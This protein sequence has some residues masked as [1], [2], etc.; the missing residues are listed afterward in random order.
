MS[1]N[2]KLFAILPKV[3]SDHIYVVDISVGKVRCAANVIFEGLIRNIKLVTKHFS[4]LFILNV[5]G[6]FGQK[7]ENDTT[8]NVKYIYKT[9]V[10]STLEPQTMRLT[11]DTKQSDNLIFLNCSDSSLV[12]KVIITTPIHCQ[13]MYTENVNRIKADSLSTLFFKCL[14][15]YY[16]QDSNHAKSDTLYILDEQSVFENPKLSDEERYFVSKAEVYSADTS[17]YTILEFY[18]I[19]ELKGECISGGYFRNKSFKQWSQGRKNGVW[20]YFDKSG[21][22][23]QL[24]EY[25]SD[26]IIRQENY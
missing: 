3:S 2:Y 22:L 21:H 5:F 23:I 8:V 20:K 15:D 10:V 13:K 9:V 18:S 12:E 24:I 25:E 11:V 26:I 4:I 19:N 17:E 7:V 16:L 6:S 14:E 1:W